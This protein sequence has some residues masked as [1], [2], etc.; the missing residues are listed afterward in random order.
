LASYCSLQ[1]LRWLLRRRTSR[2]TSRV[3]R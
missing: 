1:F 2:G 3:L